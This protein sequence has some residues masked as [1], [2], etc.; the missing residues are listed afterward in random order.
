MLTEIR[1]FAV[2]PAKNMSQIS[3][4]LFTA[5]FILGSAFSFRP[6]IAKSYWLYRK[7]GRSRL[8]LI[9][10]SEWQ[11]SA[12]GEPIG[13]YELQEDLSWSLA[14]SDEA[15]QDTELIAYIENKRAAFDQRIAS[16]QNIE[17]ML[18]QYIPSLPFYQRAFAS[19]LASSLA[20]S[21]R[22]SGIYGLN[23]SEAKVLCN[24]QTKD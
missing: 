17:Q 24:N 22:K 18:P 2:A 4:E 11:Y 21:M 20:T 9:A 14:L 3:T 16:F 1:S 8:S 5:L 15:Q 7:Q 23:Y 6:V 19:A 12:F 13:R 10:P